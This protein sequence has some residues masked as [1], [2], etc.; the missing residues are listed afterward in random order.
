MV[1]GV[2]IECSVGLILIAIGILI[3]SKQKISLLH[4]YHYKNVKE[5][6]IPAYA[7]LIGIG[8]ILIGGGICLTGILNLFYSSLWWIP[9][10]VGI[11]LGIIVMNKAQ[12]KYNGAW[13]S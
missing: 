10:F 13:F 5:D 6:D 2:I 7:R 11:V 1:V 12:N 9:L 8:L 4:E 3:W